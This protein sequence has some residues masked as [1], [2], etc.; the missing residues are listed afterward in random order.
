[1]RLFI[2][3]LALNLVIAP[4]S[5]A[6]PQDALSECIT[7]AKSNSVLTGVADSSI[8]DFCDCSLKSIIDKGLPTIKTAKECAQKAFE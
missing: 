5:I 4:I 6:Y 8:E 7:S 1:M 2:I 3:L